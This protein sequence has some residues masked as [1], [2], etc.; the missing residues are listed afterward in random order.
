MMRQ[1]LQRLRAKRAA[2]CELT[3][4]ERCQIS[5]LANRLF[6]LQ[7]IKGCTAR[8]YEKVRK[9]QAKI[10]YNWAEWSTDSLIVL[11]KN[12]Q[13]LPMLTDKNAARLLSVGEELERRGSGQ[14]TVE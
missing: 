14:R 3:Y 7:N 12:I 4:K 9:P 10:E 1:Y 11:A 13:R 8:D 6:R 5:S 2:G